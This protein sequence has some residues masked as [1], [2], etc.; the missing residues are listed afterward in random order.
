MAAGGIADQPFVSK[1][2]SDKRCMDDLV[3]HSGVCEK[4]VKQLLATYPFFAR[5]CA[6][7]SQLLYLQ[8]VCEVANEHLA[9]LVEDRRADLWGIGKEQGELERLPVITTS[10]DS[11]EHETSR[12][13][14]AISD[15]IDRYDETKAEDS[16]VIT[17]LSEFKKDN[18]YKGA[19][20]AAEEGIGLA[21]DL[22]FHI[23][24]KELNGERID[25][26]KALEHV[27][28][29]ARCSSFAK[30]AVQTMIRQRY[31]VT[32]DLIFSWQAAMSLEKHKD[33]PL[34]PAY[35]PQKDRTVEQVARTTYFRLLQ[36]PSDASKVDSAIASYLMK[37]Y[38]C[39]RDELQEYVDSKFPGIFRAYEDSLRIRYAFL[40][41]FFVKVKPRPGEESE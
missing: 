12:I 25:V 7:G 8:R 27:V 41:S 37:K 36:K 9:Q 11:L 34:P 33:T 3:L 18:L 26:G 28:E 6:I 17:E 23:V 21:K 30:T 38:K 4:E 13:A 2:T 35:T 32:N 10:L 31:Q 22:T 15:V 40:K 14:T 20:R 1:I 24:S 19:I 29:T 16:L 39:T 5:S